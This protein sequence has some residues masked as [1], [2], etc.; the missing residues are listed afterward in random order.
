M[1]NNQNPWAPWLEEFPSAQYGASIPKGTPSFMDYWRGQQGRVQQ[2]YMTTL[3]QQA[4]GGE[5]PSMRFGSF[6]ENYPFMQR[7]QMMSPQRRGLSY[8]RFAPSLRWRV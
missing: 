8:G 7:Y 1:P 3:G 2:E 5:P 4:M 6:L